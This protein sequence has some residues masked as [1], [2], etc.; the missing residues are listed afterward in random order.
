MT[1]PA[2]Y[3]GTPMQKG[4]DDSQ[5]YTKSIEGA[6]E[7]RKSHPGSE[8]WVFATPDPLVAM[9]YSLK[10]PLSDQSRAQVFSLLVGNNAPPILVFGGE[11]VAKKFALHPLGMVFELD[12]SSFKPMS[13]NQKTCEWISTDP[14]TR[15]DL[16]SVV[17]IEQA[18]KY[19]IQIMLFEGD[20]DQY[21]SQQQKMRTNG[22]SQMERVKK[23]VQSGALQHLNRDRDLNCFDFESGQLQNSEFLRNPELV[24]A[25]KSPAPTSVTRL[26][27]TG[28]IQSST[29]R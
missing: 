19:G 23:M 1:K 6:M 12:N 26:A 15:I 10:P 3:H 4:T 24:F 25:S 17:T 13:E 5:N 9:A 21:E 11:N 7:P 8:A 16:R 2:L 22:E 28:L 27:A 20:Y 14:V 29:Q 18:M